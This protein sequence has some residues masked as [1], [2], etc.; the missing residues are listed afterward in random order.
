MAIGNLFKDRRAVPLT[1][2]LPDNVKGNLSGA[3]TRDITTEL[4]RHTFRRW[5]KRF[6]IIGV[7]GIMS[8]EDA[9]EK[10][11]AGASLIALI[12]GMIFEGP[13]LAGEINHGLVRL[14][15]K[16]GFANISDAIGVKSHL[17]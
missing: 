1:D 17:E 3:P 10:I 6:I 12:T 4:V 11:Q 9:Y 8:A 2:V 14:L 16:D 13:Q 15:K 5:G 7:G